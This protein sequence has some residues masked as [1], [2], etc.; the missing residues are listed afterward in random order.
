MNNEIKDLTN[1]DKGSN[2]KKTR[3]IRE[4]KTRIPLR[5]QKRLIGVNKEP[6][7]MYRLVNDV[8]D[9][10]NSFLTAGYEIVDKTGNEV[11]VDKRIQDPSWRQSAL[12]QSVGGGIKGYVMR[13]P[14]EWYEEDQSKKQLEIDK[15]EKSKNI[16]ASKDVKTDDFYGDIKIEHN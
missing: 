8:E 2:V 15:K 11:E 13:I 9:R 1:Q 12:S 4:R 7:Y 3:V 5:E 14:I 10:I 6:G 16:K